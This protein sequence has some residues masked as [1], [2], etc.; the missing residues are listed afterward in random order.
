MTVVPGMVWTA[1]PA[2]GGSSCTGGAAASRG[3]DATD[4][5]DAVPYASARA[6]S[7]CPPLLTFEYKLSF[8]AHDHCTDG[9]SAAATLTN[10]AKAADMESAPR[11]GAVRH[12]AE[13]P[14]GQ[15]ACSAMCFAP[16]VTT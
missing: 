7:A 10:A 11:A 14:A 16:I 3:P 12:G 8:S 6:N 13:P 15:V 5:A 9:V 2:A 1:S 4:A